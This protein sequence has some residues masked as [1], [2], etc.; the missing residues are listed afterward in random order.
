MRLIESSRPIF[1]R[2]TLIFR[3]RQISSATFVDVTEPK[4]VPVGPACT[5]NVSTVF[6]SVSAIASAWSA[7]AASWRARWASRFSSSATFAGV[8]RSASLRGRRKLRA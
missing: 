3:V 8:A 4:S 6:R 5:S 7:D 2:S 1:R